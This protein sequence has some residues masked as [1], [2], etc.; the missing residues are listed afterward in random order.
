VIV[1]DQQ[2]HGRT[3]DTPREMSYEQ[4]GDDAAAL[5]RALKL[6]RA[7]VMAMSHVGISG[8]SDLLAPLVNAF[9]DDLTPTTPNRFDAGTVLVVRQDEYPYRREGEP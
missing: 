6:E 9:L 8:E 2:G 5:L 1:F 7:D 4:F 3:P